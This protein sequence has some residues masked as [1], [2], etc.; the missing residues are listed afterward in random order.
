M[1]V[2]FFFLFSNAHMQ[3]PNTHRGEESAAFGE[4]RPNQV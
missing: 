3:G 2:W 4:Q 1:E